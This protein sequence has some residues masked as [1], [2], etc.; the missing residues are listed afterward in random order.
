MH[1]NQLLHR[2]RWE[3]YER[4]H[5]PN[6]LEEGVELVL[7]YPEAEINRTAAQVAGS[8]ASEGE[9][10]QSPATEGDYTLLPPSSPGDY[11]LLPPSSPGDYTL[12]PPSSP[13]DYTLLPPSSPGD[14]TL[15]PPSSP[16]DYTLLPPSSP[17]DYTLLPPSSPVDYMLPLPPPPGAE[18][19]ELPL[20]GAACCSAS[21]GVA[22]SSAS[23]GVAASPKWQQ[24]SSW[25]HLATAPAVSQSMD[26]LYRVHDAEKLGLASIAA[27]VQSPN[28][29]LLSKDATCPNKQ[30]RVS[31]I[32]ESIQPVRLPHG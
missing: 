1:C 29:A 13:G 8:P 14:Y 7:C 22:A 30:C 10:H 24:E 18:Q 17:G 11:T 5:T 16:G 26:A 21:P 25:D 20:P 27:L 12:L 2:E 15:L 4:E 3:A 31:E 19:Q 9:P 23:P 32:R 28:L 6:S